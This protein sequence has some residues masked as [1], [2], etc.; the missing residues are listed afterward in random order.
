M[1]L[2]DDDVSHIETII[3]RS[4]EHELGSYKVPKEQHYQ[5]HLWLQKM[6]RWQ[7]T[8]QNGFCKSVINIFV[9]VIFL[10]FLLGFIFWGKINFK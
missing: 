1:A 10:I 8:I 6:I 4:I 7:D 9:S 3:K 5:D 2:T